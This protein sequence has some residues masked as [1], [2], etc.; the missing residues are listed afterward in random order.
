MLGMYDHGGGNFKFKVEAAANNCHNFPFKVSD[1]KKISYGNII[2][3][4]KY[5]K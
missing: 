3:E 4:D 5:G 2:K 1:I